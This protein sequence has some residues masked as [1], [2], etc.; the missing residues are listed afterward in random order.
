MIAS[1][2]MEGDC[3]AV[4]IGGGKVIYWNENILKK[5]DVQKELIG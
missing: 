3:W 1:L 4:P 2:I 5:T